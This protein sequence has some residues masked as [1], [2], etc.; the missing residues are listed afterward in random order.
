M[1]NSTSIDNTAVLL[2]RH[3][4]CLSIAN[5]LVQHQCIEY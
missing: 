5:K 2:S 3:Y 4:T 1:A